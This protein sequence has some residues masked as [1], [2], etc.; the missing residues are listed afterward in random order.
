MDAVMA[1]HA[2]SDPKGEG[3]GAS[4]RIGE[5]GTGANP[6]WQAGADNGQ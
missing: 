2:Q 6:I 1:G 4:W 3:K 5:Y